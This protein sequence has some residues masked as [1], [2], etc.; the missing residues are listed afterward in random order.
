VQLQVQDILT[1]IGGGCASRLWH[2]VV[3]NCSQVGHP[4]VMKALFGGPRPQN[5]RE[6][7]VLLL[8]HLLNT[9]GAGSIATSGALLAGSMC[10]FLD[11]VC[12]REHMRLSRRIYVV[13]LQFHS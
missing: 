4:R 10:C 8:S 9:L 1:T 6:M 3:S 11:Q 7:A 13:E 2:M 5:S 12:G